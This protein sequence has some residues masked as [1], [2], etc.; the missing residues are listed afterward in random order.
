MSFVFRDRQFTGLLKVQQALT[1]VGAR[2]FNENIQVSFA[3]HVNRGGFSAAVRRHGLRWRS[4]DSFDT[5]SKPAAIVNFCG[6]FTTTSTRL[7]IS[8]H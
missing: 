1:I 8:D 3:V 7:D 4:G 5:P 2:T 6:F